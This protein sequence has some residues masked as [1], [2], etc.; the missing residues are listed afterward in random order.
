MLLFQWCASIWGI[1]FSCWLGWWQALFI[2]MWSLCKYQSCPKIL[3]V[4]S[5]QLHT[6]NFN[7]VFMF[8]GCILCMESY[9][10]GQELYQW[11][12]LF[13]KEVNFSKILTENGIKPLNPT[14]IWPV[15]LMTI[16]YAHNNCQCSNENPAALLKTR[17]DDIRMYK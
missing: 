5:L 6:C 2:P 3:T 15:C 4:D 14:S 8:L 12:N 1:S 10:H 13:G 17:L 7:T 16:C 11:K 9:S